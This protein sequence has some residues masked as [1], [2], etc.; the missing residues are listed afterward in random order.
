MHRDVADPLP[1]LARRVVVRESLALVL[2]DARVDVKAQF[3]V[4][5]A[6]DGVP[7]GDRADAGDE[8]I[9]RHPWLSC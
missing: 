6:G 2:L 7:A 9:G 1:G 3:I 4:D 8:A 5:F